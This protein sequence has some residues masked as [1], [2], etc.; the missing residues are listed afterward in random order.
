MNHLDWIQWPAMAVTVAA[1]WFVASSQ[2]RRRSV[3]FWLFLMSNALWV[4]WGVPAHA[5]G[6]ITLQICLAAMNIRGQV[7]N[8]A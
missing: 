4:L 1:S 3:G 6:L 5:Y 8:S 7:K 2:R